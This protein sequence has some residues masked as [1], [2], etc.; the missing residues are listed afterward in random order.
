MSIRRR[1][2]DPG[3]ASLTGTTSSEAA[4][5]VI[6]TTGRQDFPGVWQI[7]PAKGRQPQPSQ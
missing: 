1:G 5:N 4:L 7:K 2:A 6:E 3:A